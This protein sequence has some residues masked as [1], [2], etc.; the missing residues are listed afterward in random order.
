MQ[1]IE[2]ESTT[3]EGAVGSPGQQQH[4]PATPSGLSGSR[5][6]AAAS[7]CSATLANWKGR[8]V[9]RRC[10]TVRH[11]SSSSRIRHGPGAREYC[12]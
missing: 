11:C 10:S 6:C 7:A 12:A 4:A 8:T 3:H 1:D 5:P 2:S 9:S